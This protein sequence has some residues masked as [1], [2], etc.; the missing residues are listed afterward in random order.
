MSFFQSGS[1]TKEDDFDIYD[2][3]SPNQGKKLVAKTPKIGI[4]GTKKEPQIKSPQKNS[5]GK[6]FE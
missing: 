3:N 5:L 2:E 4:F 1:D 6:S